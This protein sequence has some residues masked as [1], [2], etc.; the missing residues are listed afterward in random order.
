M[1]TRSAD[2]LLVDALLLRGALTPIM[3]T[4][5]GRH[6]VDAYAGSLAR[7]PVCQLWSG[8]AERPRLER[9]HSPDNQNRGVV[10]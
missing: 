7:C 1:A 9:R 5:C 3:C 4:Q 2:R 10:G 6:L 8:T